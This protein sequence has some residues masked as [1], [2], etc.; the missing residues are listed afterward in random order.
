MAE[1]I[2]GLVSIPTP[3]INITGLLSSSWIYIFI[4]GFLFLAGFITIGIIMFTRTYNKKVI[5]F[6]NISGLGFQPVVRAKA[7]TVSL[8]TGGYEVL[9]LLGGDYVSAYG[10]P[11][12]HNS[13]WFA[14]LE[15][16]LLYNF[17]MTD[18]DAKKAVMDVKPINLDVRGWY[19]VKDRMAKETYQKQ[20]FLEKY[21]ATIIMFFFLLAFIIGMWVIVGKIGTATKA[22]AE[23]DQA[24]IDASNRIADAIT[25]LNQKLPVESGIVPAPITVTGGG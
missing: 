20:K 23:N 21:G 6:Q 14:K 2:N 3:Q 19:V 11:M 9:K 16:G 25:L 17:V 13:Y 1:I 18:L 5:I 10:R 15:D 22:L 24:R 8:G 12:G 4:L 7:R